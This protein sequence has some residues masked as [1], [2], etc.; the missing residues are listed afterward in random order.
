[1]R[2]S[3]ILLAALAISTQA[4]PM[5]LNTAARRTPSPWCLFHGEGCW[6]RHVEP[7]SPIASSPVKPPA[8]LDAEADSWCLFHG[9]G[10]WKPRRERKEAPSEVDAWCLSPGQDCWRLKHAVY[11]FTN[12]IRDIPVAEETSAI[13]DIAVLLANLTSNS[14]EFMERIGMSSH[15]K[16]TTRSIMHQQDNE[17]TIVV[18]NTAS[19]HKS[20][21]QQPGAVCDVAK[22][23][24]K[25][26]VEVVEKPNRKGMGGHWCLFH[27]EGCWKRRRTITEEDGD[28][29]V[30]CHAEE[31]ACLWARRSLEELR[32]VARKLLDEL[33]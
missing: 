3:A 19:N 32:I 14:V 17:T 26:V 31:G 24:A 23:V 8:M 5:L 30:L 27:G 13:R 11:A 25:T 33:D 4:A 18:S 21:C 15:H 2:L 10:Y 1:M 6:K 28:V 29:G 16:A 9:A 7:A 22:R 12:V 20:I